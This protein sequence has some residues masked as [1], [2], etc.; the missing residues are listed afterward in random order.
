MML[1]HSGLTTTVSPREGQTHTT[2][3]QFKRVRARSMSMSMRWG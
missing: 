1:L 3:K 2:D